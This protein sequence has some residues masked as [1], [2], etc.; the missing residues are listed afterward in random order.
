V[1]LNNFWLYSIPIAAAVILLI[2][3][4]GIFR[5]LRRDS[6]DQA[7]AIRR[8]LARRFE[9]VRIEL[10]SAEGKIVFVF[11]VDA[12]TVRMTYKRRD[13]SSRGLIRLEFDSGGPIAFQIRQGRSKGEFDVQTSNR[14]SLN[15]LLDSKAWRWLTK[16]A[17]NYWAS[18]HLGGAALEIDV[19]SGSTRMEIAYGPGWA[20]EIIGIVLRFVDVFRQS[21]RIV[22]DQF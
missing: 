12:T 13:Q 5:A 16:L 3:F 20:S 18:I 6:L 1:E 2:A 22:P 10:T 11:T 9:N 8:C 15:Q 17:N 7:K 4:I 21:K 19:G 14:D